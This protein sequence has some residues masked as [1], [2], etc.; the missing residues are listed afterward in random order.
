MARG[1]ELAVA[2]VSLAVETSS[3]PRQIGQAFA[4]GDRVAA[5]AGK[6]MGQALARGISSEKPKLDGLIAEVERAKRAAEQAAKGVEAA[7][8]KEAQATQLVTQRQKELAAAVEKYGK[9]SSQVLAKDRQLADAKFKLGVENQKVAAAQMAQTQAQEKAAGASKALTDAQKQAADAQ[10]KVAAEAEK[11]SSSF[12][13]LRKAMA[14]VDVKGFKS[15]VSSIDWNGISRGAGAVALGIGAGFGGAVK[16]AADFEERMSAVKAV[17]GATAPELQQ[18]ADK[19]KQLG[20]D[21]AFSASESAVAI[22]EL[23]KAGVTVPQ[24]MKGAADATVAL[25]AAS[26]VTMPE[27]ATIASNAMNAFGIDASKMGRVADVIAGAANASAIDVKEFGYSLQ[28]SGAVAKLAGMGFDDLAVAVAEMGNA[29]IKGQDAGTALKTMLNNLQPSTKAA[30]NQMADLGLIAFDSQQALQKMASVGIKPLGPGY[31]QARQAISAYLAKTTGLKDDTAEMGKAVDEFMQKN[32]GLQNQFYDQQ[33]NLKS[34]RDIQDLLSRSTAGL[35]AQQ[36]QQALE[37]MFGSDAIRAAAVMAQN[38]AKGFDELS[39]AMGKV[40]AAQTAADRMGNLK[41]QI[42]QMKGSAETLAISLGEKLIPPI[43]S[44]VKSVTEFVNAF[45]QMPESQQRLWFGVAAG[46]GATAAGLFTAIKVA[47]GAVAIYQT[48]QSIRQAVA[49]FQAMRTAIMAA[50][51]AQKALNLAQRAS[52]IGIIVTAIALLVAGLIYAYN[53]SE[54]FRNI[55]NAIGSVIMGAFR[56]AVDWITNTAWPVIKGFFSGIG[57]SASDGIGRVRTFFQPLVDW[58]QGFVIPRLQEIGRIWALVFESMWKFIKPVV[59]FMVGVFM[60]NLRA[61]GALVTWLWANAI[62]PWI[63]GMVASFTAFWNFIS[64]ILA[65]FGRMIWDQLVNT[66]NTLLAVARIVWDG[67][68]QAVSIAVQI[69]RSTIE[70]FLNLL[71]GNWDLAWQNVKNIFTGIF[72]LIRLYI[73]TFVAVVMAVFRG[74]WT[75]VMLGFTWLKDTAIAVVMAMVTIIVGQFIW[76]R[77][78]I[79]AIAVTTTQWVVNAVTWL[80]RTAVFIVKTMVDGIVASFIWWRDLINTVTVAATTW[81]MDRITWL[82]DMALA[83]IRMMVDGIVDRFNW[84]RD[85]ITSIADTAKNWV[86]ERIEALKTNAM[87]TWQ[88]MVD[89]IARIWDGL[90]KAASDPVKFVIETVINKGIIKG[91]NDLVSLLKLDDKLKVTPISVPGFATGGWTG[92]GAKYAPAGVVHADEFVVRKESRQRIE[93]SNPGLLDYMNRTGS[94][95]G[96]A[97]GGRVHP[98]PG[99]PANMGRGYHGVDRGIDIP[100]PMGTPVVAMRDSTVN[101]TAKWGYSYGW[102]VR[103]SDGAIYA[104]M[105]DI[106]VAAGQV[107][108]AGQQL[109]RVGNTGNSFGP[110]LHVT[111]Y[112]GASPVGAAQPGGD[113]GGFDPLAAVMGFVTD[114]LATPVKALLDKIPGAGV[115]VDVAKGLGTRMLDS[116]IEK[117]KTLGGS[118][119]ADADQRPGVLPPGGAVERWRPVVLQALRMMNQPE[120]Y[121]DLTLRRLNQESSGNP[122]IVNN[123]DINAKNG[124]PSKGLMQVIDPTFRAYAMPGYSSNIFDPLSNILASMRYALARYGSL[125]RAYNRPGGYALGTSWAKPGLAWVGENGPELVGLNGPQLLNFRGGEGVL[126]NKKTKELYASGAGN[127]Y[128]FQPQVK[129]SDNIERQFQQ[130]V[131]DVRQRA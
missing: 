89:G 118:A 13:G 38:G 100:A 33:G 31:D 45:L 103:T 90:K 96:Y 3:V 119:P 53:H 108:K 27:A 6:R 84:W 42:E 85:T 72:D 56:T 48:G 30:Y 35:S 115:F 4:G 131:W 5:D 58:I 41:G 57:D 79:N 11:S 82:K 62:K 50:E 14:D 110:H 121:A 18:L 65:A 15:A 94:M 16:V 105:S 74:W 32:G 77:D 2:Y 69:V 112:D 54:R 114:K 101:S 46:I 47:Q 20:K 64:P 24:V 93:Q 29:G 127:N 55:V 78:L 61:L 130:F 36:R 43:T 120:S 99:W 8:H 124:T 83:G 40:T 116:A 95:P 26:G 76:W 22:E 19:A 67:I 59:D 23:V 68:K 10:R 7:R 92:P 104:H 66:F 49:A 128:Y 73:D 21:T 70:L 1:I 122:G 88:A 81:V 91:W 97:T 37:T 102:H 109:G 52:V 17:S 60:V 125:P 126:T 123:W 87:N 28:A 113:G 71:T 75:N 111:T 12:G 51:G 86:L 63:D 117:I 98:V 107:L 9:D 80:W 106:L 39:G 34:L 44:G 129:E 25:A